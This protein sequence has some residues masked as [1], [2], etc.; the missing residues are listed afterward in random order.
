VLIADFLG[1]STASDAL[2]ISHAVYT[3]NAATASLASSGSRAISLTRGSATTASLLYVGASGTRY[4]TVGINYSM[5]PGDYL[6]AWYLSTQNGVSVNVFGRAAMNLV[7]S[8]DG[9][10]TSAPLNG[11]SASTGNALPAS[12]ALTDT[13]YVRTGFSALR[14]PGTILFGTGL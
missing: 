3:F 4:R 12:V 7:G 5:T 9:V 6:F 14:Q 1:A 8:F 13:G 11:I 10:E 2:T